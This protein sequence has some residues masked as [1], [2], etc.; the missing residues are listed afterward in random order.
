M[1]SYISLFVIQG[2]LRELMDDGWEHISKVMQLRKS[3]R[4]LR[5]L[6]Y[7]EEQDLAVFR[8]FGRRI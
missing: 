5:L 8:S 7:Q 3:I 2:R 4:K 1:Y 6:S